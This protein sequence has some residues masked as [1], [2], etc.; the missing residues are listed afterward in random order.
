MRLPGEHLNWGRASTDQVLSEG[1]L[2]RSREK[3]GDVTHVFPLHFPEPLL[4]S[5]CCPRKPTAT[6]VL[7]LV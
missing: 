2:V 7:G 3:T 5:K 6:C 1:G 4:G